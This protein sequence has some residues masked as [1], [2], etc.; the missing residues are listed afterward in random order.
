M[1]GVGR[2]P[3]PEG[4]TESDIGRC[5]HAIR[6]PG[7]EYEVGVICR[8][9]R[10]V[11]FWDSWRAGGLEKQT[12]LGKNACRLKQAY[13]VGKSEEGSEAQGL[14]LDREANGEVDQTRVVLLNGKI[15]NHQP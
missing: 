6:V 15:L 7:C 3:L 4:I 14:S 10:Y 1:S 12:A 13:A 2:Y 11:L 5:N 9:D 8:D